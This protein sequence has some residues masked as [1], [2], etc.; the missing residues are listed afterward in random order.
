MF[1]QEIADEL[2]INP[3]LISFHLAVLQKEGN[4]TGEWK[5]SVQPR[6]K[7]KAAK[8]Y[9]LTPE[10]ESILSECKL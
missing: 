1:S 5:V 7:G 6:S 10:T 3:R 2:K 8:Y 9:Q 4:V